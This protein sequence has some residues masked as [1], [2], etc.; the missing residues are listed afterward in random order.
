MLRAALLALLLVPAGA[1]GQAPTPQALADRAEAAF[2]A[3]RLADAIKD[4]DQLAVLVP[5]VAPLM[6]QR[7]I[8]LYELGR[9]DECAAQFASYFKANPA[10]FENAAW[11]FFCVAREGEAI[12]KARASVLDAG[13]DRRVLRE[14]VFDMIRGRMTPEALIAL[15]DTSVGV[16]QFYGHFYAGLYYEATGNRIAALA[17]LRI[18]AGD[19][20]RDSVPF[21]HM[22]ARQDRD[23]LEK[24]I[25]R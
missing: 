16:V 10:D 20:Y 8:A 13:P 1:P 17:Q 21:L 15:A 18:A 6:W 19:E 25:A 3:G 14:Q 5:S 7:G 24:R 9:Y 22:V 11:H 23:R 12:D 4:Y 2:A